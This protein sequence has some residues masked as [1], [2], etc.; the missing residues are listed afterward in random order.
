MQRVHGIKVQ[1]SA[2]CRLSSNLDTNGELKKILS[3]P[4][5]QQMKGKDYGTI[6]SGLFLHNK[7]EIFQLLQICKEIITKVTSV[8]L[9]MMMDI[10][11]NVLVDEFVVQ[12]LKNSTISIF[13]CFL[14]LATSQYYHPSG[15]T[16]DSK[17]DGLTVQFLFLGIFPKHFRRY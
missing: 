2:P 14:F 3:P 8:A 10:S 15:F 5:A 16:G 1:R 7:W 6:R 9:T 4:V 12:Y 17:I 11:I 13:Y